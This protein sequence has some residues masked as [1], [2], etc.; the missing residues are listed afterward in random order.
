MKQLEENTLTRGNTQAMADI[1]IIEKDIDAVN[2]ID[3]YLAP[4]NYKLIIAP[5]HKK[6]IEYA[7]SA[8]PDVIMLGIEEDDEEFRTTLSTLKTDISTKNIP[9]LGIYSKL[10]RYFV[11]GNRKHGVIDYLVKPID[12]YKLL[13]MLKEL[14]EISREQKTSDISLRKNHI[15]IETPT[16]QIIKVSFKS[17]LKKY[18]L[19]EIRNVFNSNFMKAAAHREI[20]LDIRDFVSLSEEEISILEKIIHLFGN[21]KVSIIAGKHIGKILS[22]SELEAKVNLF[23]SLEDYVVFIK[24]SLSK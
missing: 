8:M 20:A 19:P 14:V 16:P 11:I 13:N 7:R 17:G 23:M 5:D 21:K 9:V 4:T 22:S 24:K 18:V 10:E 6:G 3:H 15:I 2:H 12:K 1:I